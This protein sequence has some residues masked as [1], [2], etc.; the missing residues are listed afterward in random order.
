[1]IKY[2]TVL[3]MLP[4]IY[5]IIWKIFSKDYNW[6]LL[7]NI[8]KLKINK[9]KSIRT[10]LLLK[11]IKSLCRWK[12]CHLR[13]PGCEQWN[14]MC[15]IRG[16]PIDF[17]V[18][19]FLTSSLFH[20]S[21]LTQVKCRIFWN[22]HHQVKQVSILGEMVVSGQLDA[23]VPHAAAVHNPGPGVLAK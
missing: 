15:I 13:N 6:R 22:I 7:I 19:F 12:L 16:V 14:T 10:K 17:T 18:F 2:T 9:G 23:L 3:W 11:K 1:M 20:S 8:C 21:T 4:K 5:F